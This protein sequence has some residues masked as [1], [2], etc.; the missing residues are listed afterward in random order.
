MHRLP[1]QPS[2]SGAGSSSSSS[3]SLAAV[4]AAVKASLAL[5][6][7]KAGAAAAAEAVEGAAVEQPG[8]TSKQL[9]YLVFQHAGVANDVFAALPGSAFTDSVGRHSKRQAMKDSNHKVGVWSN[10]SPEAMLVAVGGLA[11]S[12]FQRHRREIASL[13]GCPLGL[14]EIRFHDHERHNCC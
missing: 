2:S 6:C 7:R 8:D 5:A 11:G 12:A 10:A 1:P 13:L 9:L 14:V 4:A 3:S